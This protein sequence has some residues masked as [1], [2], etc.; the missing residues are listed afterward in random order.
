MKRF[1]APV[2]PLYLFLLLPAS[3]L[4]ASRRP[5]P[6]FS[7]AAS[8]VFTPD[9]ALAPNPTVPDNR[10]IPYT[11]IRFRKAFLWLLFAM[12]AALLI[13]LVRPGK[14]RLV[15]RQPP[16]QAR[17]FHRPQ[18]DPTKPHR[19]RRTRRDGILDTLP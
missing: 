2:L 17:P 15:R 6:I 7:I 12:P 1:W 10:T 11:D 3:T 14:K 9:P 19:R 16:L 8:P 13:A 4:A 18:I 5:T